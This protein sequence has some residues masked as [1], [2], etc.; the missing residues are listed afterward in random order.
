MKFNKTNLIDHLNYQINHL[1]AKWGFNSN[2][3]WALVD[4]ADFQIVMSYGSYSE[5]CEL[6]SD[7]Q[8]GNLG[9]A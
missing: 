2:N 5:L 9:A 3:G 4:K 8:N 1:E 7:I 6:V